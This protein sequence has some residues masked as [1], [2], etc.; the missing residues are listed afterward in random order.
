LGGGAGYSHELADW[1][2][3]IGFNY[4]VSRKRQVKIY[5]EFKDRIT[6][7]TSLTNTPGYIPTLPAVLAKKDPCDYYREK[8]F[9]LD[10]SLRPFR[11]TTLG[12]GFHSYDQKSVATNS[13]YSLFRKDHAPRVNPPIV[14]GKLQSLTAR[15][16]LDSRKLINFKGWVSPSFANSYVT[17]DARLEVS[18]PDFGSS[19]F[20]FKRY[21]F[22]VFARV[23]P[24]GSSVTTLRTE[25]GLS[26]RQL[27][28]QEFF[29]V[30]YG[31]GLLLSQ[32]GFNTVGEQ[33]FYGDRAFTAYLVHDFG[34]K[35]FKATRL[36]LLSG[37]P[38]GL[39]A[40]GGSFWTD[41]RLGT[42]V[43][44]SN[45]HSAT[46]AYSELGFSLYNLT[47]F[48]NPFNL[49]IAV[50]WQLSDYDTNDYYVHLGMKL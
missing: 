34:R 40:H 31:Y 41:F 28:P 42:V 11:Y 1:Q 15:L 29:S 13:D 33:P 9:R 32:R 22:S 23:R 17:F 48:I 8:G 5:A 4:R 19:D 49:S 43:P 35:F 7:R 50:T 26:D 46:T 21:H 10:L 38:F 39:S 45:Q 47:P 3:G 18:S 25:L 24:Y 2:G 36:P 6:H 44:E 12:L 20:H 27:P 30:D 16:S 37:L 14:D